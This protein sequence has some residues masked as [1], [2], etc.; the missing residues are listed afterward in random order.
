MRLLTAYAAVLFAEN[1]PDLVR[2]AAA[3]PS[4]GLGVQAELL[5]AVARNQIDVT[6]EIVGLA[7]LVRERID[8]LAA[9]RA[10]SRRRVGNAA[11]IELARLQG[12]GT[13]A[14]SGHHRASSTPDGREHRAGAA[15][16]RSALDE[17]ER[18]RKSAR[19]GHHGAGR[20]C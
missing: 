17:A 9:G 18:Y 16:G 19:H 3:D 2:T 20:H 7:A 10:A 11:L 4:L 8:R 5:R 15:G 14:P 13:N 6:D 1:E 12:I